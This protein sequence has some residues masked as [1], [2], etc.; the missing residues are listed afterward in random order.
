MRPANLLDISRNRSV[1]V[2]HRCSVCGYTVINFCTVTSLVRTGYEF[3]AAKA[4]A[5]AEETAESQMDALV[6]DIVSCCE[7]PHS[8]ARLCPSSPTN[9]WSGIDEMEIDNRT[10]SMTRISALTGACPICGNREPWQKTGAGPA[11]R[12]LPPVSFPTVYDTNDRAELDALLALQE[13]IERG[14]AVRRDPARLAEAKETHARLLAERDSLRN[15]LQN[16]SA[17]R[18]IAALEGQKAQIE[19]ELKATGLMAFKAKREINAR[20]EEVTGQIDTLQ[21][22]DKKNRE[23]LL[24]ALRRD[25]FELERCAV[26]SSE[27]GTKVERCWSSSAVALRLYPAQ[28]T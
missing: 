12:A 22:E 28:Q 17:Q 16:D 26:I 24:A 11:I 25:E 7:K 13:E 6:A 19:A 21:K 23:E 4:Q 20:L 18:Q 9:P 3:G 14:E 15:S 5:H 2:S 10:F 27:G 1:A 8:L